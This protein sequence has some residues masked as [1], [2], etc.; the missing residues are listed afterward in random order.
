LI[1][2]TAAL[3][4]LAIPYMVTGSF[5]SS[6][7]GEPRSTHD[8]DI[9]VD[10]PLEKADSLLQEFPSPRFFVQHGPAMDAIRRRKMFNILD[11]TSGFKI[12]FWP[13]GNTEFDRTRFARR[14]QTPFDGAH[15]W[16]SRPEDTILKKL[17]WA[18]DSGGS[19]KQF[20][21]ALRV[22][23]LQYAVLDLEYV[24]QWVPRLEVDDLWKRLVD[25]ARPL[26]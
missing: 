23:E 16:I 12:D 25:E 4:R 2:V 20:R 7:Q 10:V 26:V 1:E 15:I 6:L 5:A 19:E 11:E 21:D 3:E 22:Y 18:I 13:V 24:A 17:R 8:L 9:V 14:V